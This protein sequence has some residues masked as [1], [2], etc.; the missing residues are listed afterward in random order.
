MIECYNILYNTENA[1]GNENQSQYRTTPPPRPRKEDVLFGNGDDWHENACIHWHDDE[2]AYRRGFRLAGDYLA[3]HVCNTGNDQDVL[4]YPIVYLYRHHAELVLK[5]IIK[6]ASALLERELTARDLKKLGWHGLAELW[7]TTKPLLGPV[8]EMAGNP[9]FPAEDI[10]GIDSYIRQIHE[11]DP[12][13]QRFRYATLKVTRDGTRR[14]PAIPTPSLREE[15]TIL[16][17]RNFAVAMDKL[18]DYLESIEG[19]FAELRHQRRN[20]RS[21][22]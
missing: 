7:E 10:E 9:P 4:V 1:V 13:G 15:L 22:A 19:W 6:T 20:M 17:V 2:W 12:D 14:G 18:A 8:C 21:Q 11:H 16:N 5:A 3:E